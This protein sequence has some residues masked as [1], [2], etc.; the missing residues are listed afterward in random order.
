MNTN[1]ELL[2]SPWNLVNELADEKTKELFELDDILTSISL[3]LLK[4]QGFK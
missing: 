3:K 2:Q 1:K 4:L